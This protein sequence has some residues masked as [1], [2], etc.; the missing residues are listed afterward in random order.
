MKVYVWNSAESYR[1]WATKT[2]PPS[3]TTVS[4]PVTDDFIPEGNTFRVCVVNE[5]Q[6]L[7]DCKTAVREYGMS[8][9]NV[10]LTVP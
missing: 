8:T 5:K 4:V 10:Y 2:V 7:Q 6:D 9:I 3:G 1:T